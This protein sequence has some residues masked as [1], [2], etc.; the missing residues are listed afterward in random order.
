MTAPARTRAEVVA[1]KVAAMSRQQRAALQAMAL[2]RLVE[3]YIKHIPHPTQMAFLSLGRYREVLFG[4]A[5]GGGKSDALLMAA[6]QY[7]DVPGYSALLLR[8]TWPDLVLPGAIMDRTAQWLGDTPARP[9]EGG[10]V[11]VFPSGARLQFG[12]L[13]HDQQKYRYQSAEFQFVGYDELTQWKEESTYDYLFSRLRKPKIN[14]MN[15]R[16]KLTK[17][18]GSRGDWQFQHTELKYRLKANYCKANPDPKVLEQYPPAA[19]GTTI[20]DVPLRMRAATNPGGVGN[21]WVKARFIN[22]KTRRKNTIFVPSKLYD[23]PSLD[24][25]Y[26]ESLAYLNEVD[27]LR[28]LEGDWDVQEAGE[29]FD[30]GDFI[31]VE[32]QPAD[33]QRYVRYWDKASTQGGGDW[34]VGTLMGILPD[35]KVVILDQVRFQGHPLT[36]EKRVRATAEAD[37]LNVYIR[38]EQEPGSSG[39]SIIDHYMRN[40]LNGF[41]YD[42]IRST[43]SKEARATAYSGAV[44]A[45]NVL[46]MRAHWNRD[47]LNEHEAFPMGGHDDQVDSAAGAFNFLQLGRRARLLV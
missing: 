3:P 12:Y 14:C 42:G 43:G 41:M 36:N 19:D 28:L 13:Q 26:R 27:R 5:A 40:V 30:R 2:P 32:H 37:G 46:V 6:L 29:F 38:E 11:W 18:K 33:I 22:S 23:N 34:T 20:F 21:E 15:C 24:D 1:A 47:F 10:R 45:H 4:G 39:K 31:F 9:K 17:K 8:K 16:T 7:V 44:K 25:S 35:N